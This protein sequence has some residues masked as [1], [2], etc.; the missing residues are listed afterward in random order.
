LAT[1][2][3]NQSFFVP[4]ND[5]WR[6]DSVDL[7][8]YFGQ[9]N[10]QV[11]FRN[12]GAFGNS[13]YIDNVNLGSLAGLNTTK[14][15]SISMYPNPIQT[16]TCLTIQGDGIKRVNLISP[17]GKSIK[18]ERKFEGNTFEIPENISTGTYILQIE[19]EKKLMN[20]PL[21]IIR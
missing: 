15:P 13:L 6:T 12:I 21:I 16:G 5:Q 19:S 2:P 10:L 4:T 20:K 1:S 9:S 17:E 14:L 11:A 18:S 3:D 8:A 7:S